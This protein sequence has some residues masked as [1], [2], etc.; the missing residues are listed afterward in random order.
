MLTINLISKCLT[1]FVCNNSSNDI[2][3]IISFLFIFNYSSLYFNVL[4]YNSNTLQ[5]DSIKCYANFSYNN[6]SYY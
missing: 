3:C 5:Y 2:K 1:Y 4:V 6:K